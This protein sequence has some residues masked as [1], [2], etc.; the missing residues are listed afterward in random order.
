MRLSSGYEER[1]GRIEI[2]PLIDIIFLLLVFFIYAMVTMTVQ[3]GIRV[4]LP[5]ASG[6][7]AP[8]GGFV[9]TLTSSNTLAVDG[10]AMTVDQAV[11]EAAAAAR[12]A[13]ETVLIN[14]DRSADLGMA[15]ELVAKLRE[16]GVKAVSFLVKP[17]GG[18]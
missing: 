12:K 9:I 18:K 5:A 15:V 2:V 3:K 6:E 11:A 7:V 14:G 13:N 16:M 10:R 17:E 8:R 1:K 4:A